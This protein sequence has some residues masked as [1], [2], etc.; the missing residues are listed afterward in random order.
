MTFCNGSRGYEFKQDYSA[1][2]LYDVVGVD[3]G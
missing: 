1:R 2:L 3:L